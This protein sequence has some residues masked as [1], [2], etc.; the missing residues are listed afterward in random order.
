MV[1]VQD[2]IKKYKTIFNISTNTYF[3]DTFLPI[4]EGINLFNTNTFIVYIP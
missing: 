1:E 4:K 2:I 3:T